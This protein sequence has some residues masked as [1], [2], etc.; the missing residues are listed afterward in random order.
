MIVLTCC[1]VTGNMK[2]LFNLCQR[3]PSLKDLVYLP[4]KKTK[5]KTRCNVEDSDNSKDNSNDGSCSP[6]KRTMSC[7]N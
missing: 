3:S 1:V 4:I 2:S 6:V 7:P 5:T